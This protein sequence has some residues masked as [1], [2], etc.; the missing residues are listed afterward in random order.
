MLK[1]FILRYRHVTNEKLKF[2][3]REK[4]FH[5]KKTILLC[6]Q[7]DFRYPTAKVSLLII[8]LWFIQIEREKQQQQWKHV[9]KAKIFTCEYFEKKKW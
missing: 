9:P 3:I 7:I 6:F 4:K 5:K 2:K 8:L 1:M